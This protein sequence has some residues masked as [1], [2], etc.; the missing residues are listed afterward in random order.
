M[1][2][3]GK[4]KSHDPTRQ[5]HLTGGRG[6]KKVSL[7]SLK[8]L[9]VPSTGSVPKTRLTHLDDKKSKTSSVATPTSVNKPTRRAGQ[10]VSKEGH[11]LKRLSPPSPVK[12]KSKRASET[13]KNNRFV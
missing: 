5:P 8:S 6:H 11:D 2:K 10:L 1:K 12:E 3:H 7:R 9:D 4:K 13:K